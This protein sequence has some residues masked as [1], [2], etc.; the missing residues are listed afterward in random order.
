M[1][2]QIDLNVE[3]IHCN[4]QGQVNCDQNLWLECGQFTIL[5]KNTNEECSFGYWKGIFCRSLE[6]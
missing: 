6:K 5:C 3:Q 2:P 1:Y 4:M